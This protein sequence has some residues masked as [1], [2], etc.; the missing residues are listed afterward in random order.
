[1]T[2]RPLGREYLVYYHDH[3]THIG[4]RR[5]RL[6]AGRSSDV[7]SEQA[8]FSLS[9]AWVASTSL[10]LGRSGLT[11]DTN[12]HVSGEPGRLTWFDDLQVCATEMASAQQ[13][14]DELVE[15]FHADGLD[16]FVRHISAVPPLKSLAVFDMGRPEGLASVFTGG[17]LLAGFAVECALFPGSP[18]RA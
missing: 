3:R 18:A 1:M 17:D 9:L 7:R 10:Q 12:D 14:L 15:L 5:R 11:G 6:P 4:L 2:L 13:T 8:K 16:P